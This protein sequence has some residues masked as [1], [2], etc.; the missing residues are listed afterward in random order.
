ME[1]YEINRKIRELLG[2]S[3]REL[4]ERVGVT[5]QAIGHYESGYAVNKPTLRVIEW[6]LDLI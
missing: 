2:L 5:K 6:E 4:A 3:G 1:R